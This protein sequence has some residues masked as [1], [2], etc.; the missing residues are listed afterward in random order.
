MIFKGY[1][2]VFSTINNEQYNLIGEF[3]DEMLLKHDMEELRGLG[4][5]WTDKNIEYVI[6]LKNNEKINDVNYDWKEI[7]IPDDKWEIVNGK[8]EELDKI[9]DNIYKISNLKYEIEIFNNDGTCKIM[10]IR[11]E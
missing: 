9:Y 3:W 1:S 8:T 11:E 4:Y 7:N 10:Y 5:N 2:R 6:G